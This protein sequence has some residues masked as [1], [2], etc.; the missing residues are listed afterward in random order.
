MKK[1]LTHAAFLLILMVLTPS[2]G[3]AQVVQSFG[4]LALRVNLDDLVRVEDPR[5][6]RTTGRVTRLTGGEI[7]LETAVGEKRFAPDAVRE[8]AVRGHSL[9]RGALIGAAVFAA[10]GAATVC[11][12]EGD[13]GCAIVGSL[14]AAPIGA[15]LGLVAGAL[16]PR[17]R[18]VYL[19]PQGAISPGRAPA[20]GGVQASLLEDLGLRVNL[21][22][23]LLVDDRS[24]ARTSGRLTR[25]TAD[26]MTLQTASGEKRFGRENLRQVAVRHRPLRMAVLIGAAAGATAGAIAAC[27]GQDREECPD[28][29]LIIGGL[30]AGAGLAV[31]ALMHGTTVVYPDA[32]RR[33]LIVPFVSRNAIGVRI[34]RRW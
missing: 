19:A 32:T 12:H 2:P 3:S 27:T 22:D 29:W 7:A 17:M 31:G 4:D 10:I 18:T 14:G 1:R 9:R 21:G 30:G 11:A 5:G 16:V 6:I 8:V 28:A 24:G 13:G 26:E 15:G 20:P 23:Q 34:I 25:F 33:G